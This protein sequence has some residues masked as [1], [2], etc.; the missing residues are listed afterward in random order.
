MAWIRHGQWV[1]SR[2]ATFY[3]GIHQRVDGF[4]KGEMFGV[5]L[6]ILLLNPDF[7]AEDYTPLTSFN[8][9]NLS[10]S[11]CSQ[12][13]EPPVEGTKMLPFCGM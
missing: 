7:I 10:G 9:W 13:L 1:K 4:I 3:E 2:Q 8:T 6:Q 12:E 5:Y 11:G